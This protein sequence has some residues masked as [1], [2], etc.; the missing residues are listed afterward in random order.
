MLILVEKMS[1]K[2]RPDQ[3]GGSHVPPT[4]LGIKEYKEQ[5][6]LSPKELSRDAA[7]WGTSP[8][9]DGRHTGSSE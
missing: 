3:R 5:K 1:G 4:A 7:L 6:L 9:P 8:F 2:Y